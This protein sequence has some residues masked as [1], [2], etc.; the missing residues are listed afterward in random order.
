M[1]QK[2]TPG[3][4]STSGAATI[5]SEGIA[6][7]FINIGSR[8][9]TNVYN[10]DLANDYEIQLKFMMTKKINESYLMTSDTTAW[11]VF[12]LN[13]K[14]D[15][16]GQDNKS[17]IW[18]GGYYGYSNP[19]SIFDYY[20]TRIDPEVNKWYILRISYNGTDTYS[21]SV[22]DEYY[23]Y[24][25]IQASKNNASYNGTKELIHHKVTNLKLPMDRKDKICYGCDIDY[26]L[27]GEPYIQIDL[28]ESY[29]KG[30][31]GKLISS[32]NL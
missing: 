14:N 17:C 31:D 9:T 23:N 25:P 19:V 26:R 29:I 20:N 21:I 4:V 15:V 13:I 2:Y 28:A 24:I 10:T 6:S 12:E 5:S 22:Q 32:W 3:N 16:S 11:P 30:K 7:N 1:I 27:G 18:F 8:V